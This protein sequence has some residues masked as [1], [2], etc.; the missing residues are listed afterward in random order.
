MFDQY[1]SDVS[2]QCKITCLLVQASAAVRSTAEGAFWAFLL[3]N[4]VQ[5]GGILSPF[6]ICFYI[7]DLIRVVVHSSIVCCIFGHYINVLAYADDI[8]LLVQS[9]VDPGGRGGDC[10]PNKNKNIPGREYLFAPSKFLVN[11]KKLHQECTTNHHFEIQNQKNFW[12]GT[13]P[14]SFHMGNRG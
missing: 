13:V 5:Q 6:L 8:V 4:G 14:R 11:C 2:C 7:I 12:G 1:E 10:P 9:G 3:C